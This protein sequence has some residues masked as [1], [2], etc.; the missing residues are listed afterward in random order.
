MSKIRPL[1]KFGRGNAKLGKNVYHFSLPSGFTCPM[2]LECL[3]RAN[4]KTGKIT[5]GKQ[6]KFRCFSASQEC[7]FPSVRKARWHNFDALKGLSVDGMAALIDLSLPSKANII[8]IHVGGDF[9]SQD[10]FDAWLTVAKRNPEVL[11]YAYTKNLP[12]WIARLDRIPSNLVLTASRGGKRDDLIDAYSLREARVIY[13]VAEAE[14]L[15]LEIDHDDSKAMSNGPSFALL[16]HGVQP[17][18]SFASEA[19]RAL[20][21]LGSYGRLSKGKGA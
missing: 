6:T 9:F 20:N 16:I 19:K 14:S 8:R 17:A 7:I 10:Y 1:L 3:S 2:A 5:D 4:R 18:G 12:V 13:S 15:G 11:F 21:G